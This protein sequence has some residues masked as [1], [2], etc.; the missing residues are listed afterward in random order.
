MKQKKHTVN[1][2]ILLLEKMCYKLALE[3]NAIVDAIN[4]TAKD[5]KEPK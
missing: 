2:R 4:K 5:T 3:V 1:E